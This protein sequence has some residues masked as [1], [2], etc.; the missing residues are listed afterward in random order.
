M[1][2]LVAEEH[3]VLVT[4][5]VEVADEHLRIPVGGV[6]PYGV[7]AGLELAGVVEQ[8]A[9][10][11]GAV[12][13]EEV[14]AAVVMDVDDGERA[15]VPA[16]VGTEH[17]GGGVGEGDG[18]ALGGG[19][20]ES[21]WD[22]DFGVDAAFDG[23][24]IDGGAAALGEQ[25]AVGIEGG[26]GLVGASE[27]GEC[28]AEVVEGGGMIGFELGD[29]VEE[30]GGIL[31]MA[32]IE[33]GTTEEVTDGVDG[34]V[35][36]L[37]DLEFLDGLFGLALTEQGGAEDEVSGGDVLIEAQEFLGVLGSAGGVIGAEEGVGEI[38]TGVGVGGLKGDRLPERIGGFGGVV[39]VVETAALDREALELIFEGAAILGCG[40]LG[41]AAGEGGEAG[42]DEGG[43]DDGQATCERGPG[44]GG[45]RG[46]G[47]HGGEG[48]GR[49]NGCKR[50][51]GGR[52][53]RSE[54]LEKGWLPRGVPDIS[55]R[56]MRSMTGYG[57]GEVAHD[58]CKITVE[59]SS[60]NRRQS[61]ISVNLPRD[62]D[63]LEARIRDELN[64]HLSR[65]RVSVRV[66]L[67]SGDE[68]RAQSVRVNRVLASAYAREFARIGEELGLDGRPT[69][70]TVLRAP[71]VLETVDQAPDAEALW[72]AVSGALA[73]ALKQLVQMRET[74]GAHLA[75]DLSTRLG[76]LR[77]AAAAV[78]DRAPKVAE[79]YLKQLRER[80][81]STGI[82]W[83]SEDGERLMKEVALFADR[84]DITEELTRLESHFVQFEQCLASPEPVGRTLDF[85]A[86]E[87]N[88]EINTIGS[89]ANDAAIAR[90]VVTLKAELER[91]REQ[92][93]NLE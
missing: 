57:C 74:E 59:L 67:H 2:A 18:E 65:G 50:T 53:V 20:F 11:A 3:D 42:E 48:T 54:T 27:T 5:A 21:E 19:L 38:L 44:A 36:V 31:E 89:K 22:P 52:G 29:L 60:V 24:L 88:R 41:A 66:M 28:L 45:W 62:L 32:D 13:N 64:R 46:P 23:S 6:D 72:P 87:L 79:H 4:V 7:G 68:R 55:A 80:I 76:V 90:E 40:L 9:E 51:G 16:C 35:D 69:L 81:A 85:L 10:L 43:D 15:G 71:G 26:G 75:E 47:R 92:S 78:R 14:V 8:Q 25:G 91:I 12:A 17:G 39:G 82:V 34:A 77:Q 33:V 56:R 37:G 84:S 86:Q 70:E 61:E 63:V 49:G 73:T 58:G 1:E 83:S 30:G 93:Q